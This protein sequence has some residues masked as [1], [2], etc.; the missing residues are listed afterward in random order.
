M[1]NQFLKT[2]CLRL[3][4]FHFLRAS[5]P[6]PASTGCRRS[7]L[8]HAGAEVAILNVNPLNGFLARGQL[9]EILK[10]KNKSTEIKAALKMAHSLLPLTSQTPSGRETEI[11]A[12]IGTTIE[13]TIAEEGLRRLRLD[14]LRRGSRCTLT[15]ILKTFNLRGWRGIT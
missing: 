14:S 10:K 4:R 3:I 1:I 6:E 7:I 5:T 12:N 13:M 11:H 2:L 9:H 15:R 8:P